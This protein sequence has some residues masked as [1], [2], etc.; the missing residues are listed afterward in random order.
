MLLRIAEKTANLNKDKAEII[1][2]DNACKKEEEN[3]VP[4]SLFT[5][6]SLSSDE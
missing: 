5:V 4:S 6:V 1:A 2:S 3:V